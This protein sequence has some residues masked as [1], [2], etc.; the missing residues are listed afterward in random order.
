MT[1]RLG[2]RLVYFSDSQIM[3]KELEKQQR[4][5]AEL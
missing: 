4:I 5:D 2:F 1:V 3:E